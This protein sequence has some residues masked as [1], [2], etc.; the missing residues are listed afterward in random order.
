VSLG[1]Q[2]AKG[3]GIGLALALGLCLAVIWFVVSMPGHSY[4]GEPDG[5]ADAIALSRALRTHVVELA[6]KIGERNAD[7]HRALAEAASYISAA[8]EALGCRPTRQS[9][10]VWSGDVDNVECEFEGHERPDEVVVVG[11]H[12]DSAPY[13]PGAND[14]ASGVAGLIELA[15]RV[16]A[17]PRA[18]TLRFVA[19]TNEE[20][21]FFQTDQMG[22]YVYVQRLAER[23]GTVVAML[24]IETIGSYSDEPGSQAFPPLMDLFY[25]DRGDFIALIAN[26]PSRGLVRRAIRTFRAS[27]VKVPSEGAAAPA[28]LEGV[29]WPDQWAFWLQGIPAIMI[30]DTAPFRYAAYHTRHDTPEKL[31][32]LRMASVVEGL[33][34]V[35]EELAEYPLSRA[36]RAGPSP[37]GD[38]RCRSLLRTRRGSPGAARGSPRRGP[39]PGAVARD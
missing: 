14:N 2:L 8:F 24:S 15:K 17:K 16:A 27:G 4:E 22:S 6:E 9:I 36:L 18:R 3:T 30:T 1:A 13:S 10:E 35:V 38:R 7:Q 39:A 19:F 31:D 23:P 32:Y 21:P 5:S 34:A 33:V 11:A 26:P 20:P 28:F 25:P 29:D 12:Y 37:P